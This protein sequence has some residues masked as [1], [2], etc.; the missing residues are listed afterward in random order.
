MSSYTMSEKIE[1]EPL[2]IITDIDDL[3]SGPRRKRCS[4]RER[5]AAALRVCLS[6]I[7]L[8]VLVSLFLTVV[9]KPWCKRMAFS[10]HHSHESHRTYQIMRQGLPDAHG[11]R[12]TTIYQLDTA[13]WD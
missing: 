12:Q 4:C 7:V 13:N 10:K 3:E 5:K 11:M 8:V 2:I 9:N 6:L 1:K